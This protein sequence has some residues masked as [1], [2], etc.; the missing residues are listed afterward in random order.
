MTDNCMTV[1]TLLEELKRLPPD[2]EIWVSTE[3]H[4]C[5]E[6]AFQVRL[7]SRGMVRIDA[8]YADD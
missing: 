4:G 7:D 2:A 8:G 5:F 3:C 6:P 1:S